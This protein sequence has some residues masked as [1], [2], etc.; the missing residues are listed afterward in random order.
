MWLF[1][2]LEVIIVHTWNQIWG[3]LFANI[4][5]LVHLVFITA[6]HCPHSVGL[7]FSILYVWGEAVRLSPYMNSVWVAEDG[8]CKG[9]FISNNL[10]TFFVWAV[11]RIDSQ[12][13]SSDL[14][15]WRKL[16][17]SSWRNQTLKMPAYHSACVVDSRTQRIGNV[18]LLP[19]KSS[20]RSPVPSLPKDAKGLHFFH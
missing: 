7:S 20:V 5:L 1:L 4:S 15:F 8:G 19:V 17:F 12:R 14:H 2:H 10:E 9:S 18:A 6:I 3:N 16:K 13:P 11:I